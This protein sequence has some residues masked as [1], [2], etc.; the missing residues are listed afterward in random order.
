M[1]Q[2]EY[3]NAEYIDLEA[4]EN[5]SSDILA[6]FSYAT[7]RSSSITIQGKVSLVFVQYY[8]CHSLTKLSCAP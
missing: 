7:H 6:F 3:D 4:K 1:T 2:A 5:N 8:P